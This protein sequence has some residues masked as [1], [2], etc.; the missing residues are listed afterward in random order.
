MMREQIGPKYNRSLIMREQRIFLYISKLSHGMNKS[1][2]EA[3]QNQATDGHARANN[4]MKNLISQH[5]DKNTK[6]C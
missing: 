2:D 3:I 4:K 6:R 5:A 1:T